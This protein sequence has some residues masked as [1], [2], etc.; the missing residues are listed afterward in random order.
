MKTINFLTYGDE[1][2]IHEDSRFSITHE[3]TGSFCEEDEWE[4]VVCPKSN[5]SIYE[6]LDITK[7]I[8]NYDIFS[9]MENGEVVDTEETVRVCHLCGST[10][11][12]KYCTN[13]TC[14]EFI[15]ENKSN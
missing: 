13:N 11:D 1:P 4:C 7:E 10:C 9:I 2:I 14:A 6:I 12:N 3:N 15:R 8:F 5:M